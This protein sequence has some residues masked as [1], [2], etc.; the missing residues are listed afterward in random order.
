MNLW[1]N[2]VHEEW[3]SLAA[4]NPARAALELERELGV[5]RRA[6]SLTDCAA[7]LR[8]LGI[9]A[10]GRMELG[11]S[12]QWLEEAEAIAS[13]VD[14]DLA[15]SC[16]I[17]LAATLAYSGETSAAI[18]YLE[19][20]ARDGQ[21]SNRSHAAA[22]LLAVLGL[23]GRHRQAWA[24]SESVLRA[25]ADDPLWLARVHQTRSMLQLFLGDPAIG[26]AEATTAMK[27]YGALGNEAGV[28]RCRHNLAALRA[29]SGDVIG[30]LSEYE[31]IESE[32]RRLEVPVALGAD[33]RVATLLS[34][35]LVEDALV[36]CQMAV[37]DHE[38]TGA[39]GLMV[40]SAIWWCLSLAHCG[41]WSEL[42]EPAAKAAA[43]AKAQDRPAWASFASALALE[44]VVGGF[45]AAV[46]AV[47]FPRPPGSSLRAVDVEAALV[48]GRELRDH[49]WAQA[50]RS[51]LLAALLI[52]PQTGLPDLD[53]LRRLGGL[54][55]SGLLEHRLLGA[56]A[57]GTAIAV[58]RPSALDDAV[59]I[60]RGAVEDAMDTD[61]AQAFDDHIA[62]TSVRDTLS[63]LIT[64]SLLF[65][66]DTKG[67]LN[68]VEEQRLISFNE[69]HHLKTQAEKGDSIT[70]DLLV[71]LRSLRLQGA[72]PADEFAT[73]NRMVRQGEVERALRDR[74]TRRGSRRHAT[75]VGVLRSP[76]GT[77]SVSFVITGDELQALTVDEYGHT[78]RGTPVPLRLVQTAVDRA[79]QQTT[80]ANNRIGSGRTTLGPTRAALEELDSLLL[81]PV[82]DRLD[83]RAVRL[84]TPPDLDLAWSALPSFVSTPL[85]IVA[86][87]HDQ[88]RQLTASEIPTVVSIAGPGLAFAAEEAARVHCGG[89]GPALVGAAATH[90]AFVDS[91]RTYDIVHVA[92]HADLRADQPLFSSLDFFDGPLF[93]HEVGKL[94]PFTHRPRLADLV[95]LSACLAGRQ[96]D[97]RS[98]GASGF[99]R[100]LRRIGVESVIAAHSPVADN[101]S[102]SVMVA[103]HRELAAGSRPDVALAHVRSS[104][105]LDEAERFSASMFSVFGAGPSGP[106]RKS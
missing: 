34:A 45:V 35:G 99:A 75:P 62:V 50:T 42:I 23:S 57:S 21:A 30:A 89:P 10:R 14:G 103:L 71:E 106:P 26:S 95:V 5:A 87:L 43:A 19:V 97:R 104:P 63:T 56:L 2:P 25:V 68:W 36:E 58:E 37:R 7:A 83:G 60:W 90:G 53:T 8:A 12:R 64:I 105:D 91:L 46:T 31:A 13:G 20:I 79:N 28:A 38:E 96:V 66:N 11:L 29:L 84:S 17:T 51:E 81:G 70:D 98:S 76:A 40:E 94:K 24:H 101:T 74:S 41:R 16:R 39:L 22:Q 15:D 44:G 77:L 18:S 102:I 80:R 6:G 78:S 49:G 9:A 4:S 73:T 67:A 100:T 86:S 52:R 3:F 92:C 27:L 88:V 65:Q 33:G 54:R 47:I 59:V 55:S 48:I 93:L 32:F 82:C 1:P 85:A 72:A 69:H 61:Q